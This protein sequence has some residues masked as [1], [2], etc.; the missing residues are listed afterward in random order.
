MKLSEFIALFEESDDNFWNE[1]ETWGG[2]RIFYSKIYMNCFEIEK[3]RFD[4]LTTSDVLA[5]KEMFDVERFKLSWLNPSILKDGNIYYTCK[6]FKQD[7]SLALQVNDILTCRELF[8]LLEPIS[9]EKNLDITCKES[10]GFHLKINHFELDESSIELLR[11]EL[12]KYDTRR[13]F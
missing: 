2:T 6:Y 1:I 11:A 5:I 12:I 4:A 3:K 13:I 10:D 8:R 9:K 7:G